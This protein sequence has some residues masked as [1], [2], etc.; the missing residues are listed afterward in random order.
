[1]HLSFP[2]LVRYEASSAS[3]F[4]LPDGF[5]SGSLESAAEIAAGVVSLSTETLAFDERLKLTGG[6]F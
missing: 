1:M 4:R 6:I 3:L 5:K 2:A